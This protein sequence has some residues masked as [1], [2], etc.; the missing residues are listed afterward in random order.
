MRC[1]APW[2]S[3][4][5]NKAVECLF[6][7]CACFFP[8]FTIIFVG[9]LVNV[10]ISTWNPPPPRPTGGQGRGKGGPHIGL[11]FP[12]VLFL[13]SQRRKKTTM[14]KKG[15]EKVFK[16]KE[17][18]TMLS[19]ALNP[20]ISCVGGSFALPPPSASAGFHRHPV[21]AQGACP[22]EGRGSETPSCRSWVG[23]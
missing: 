1:G 15:K 17:R 16:N 21:T 19:G 12:T 22:A 10:A 5:H 6:F 2:L 9:V 20:P 4:Q 18:V 14:L 13:S 7:V 8:L 23:V 11:W 3:P